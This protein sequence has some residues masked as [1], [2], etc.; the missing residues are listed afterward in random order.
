VD[1][2]LEGEGDGIELKDGEIVE[3]VVTGVESKAW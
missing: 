3:G 2:A 1:A